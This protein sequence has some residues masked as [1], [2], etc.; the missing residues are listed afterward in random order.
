MAK[1]TIGWFY[2]LK[3]SYKVSKNPKDRYG[4]RNILYLLFWS[5][6][7]VVP[8]Q[9][10]L[11]FPYCTTSDDW[12]VKTL[13]WFY[14]PIHLWDFGFAFKFSS[15]ITFKLLNLFGHCLVKPLKLGFGQRSGP[16]LSL[17]CW[18]LFQSGMEKFRVMFFQNFQVLE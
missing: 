3:I 13:H 8:I 18:N 4:W 10:S 16:N 6:K 2:P 9:F 11:I 1:N 7:Y 12:R 17:H 14:S 15:I 5:I